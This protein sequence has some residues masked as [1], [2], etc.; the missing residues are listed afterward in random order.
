MLTINGTRRFY[1]LPHLHDMRCKAPRIAEIIRSRYHRDPLNGDVFI[2]LSKRRNKVKMIHY[3]NHSYW[4]HEKSY[5][6]GY[7]FMKVRFEGDK[8]LY[9]V[10]WKDLVAIL[11][12]PVVREISI[13]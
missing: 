7:N 2:Y 1:F 5:V 8:P 9:Q 3:E 10:N 12:T 13:A 6:N 4:V 11:E